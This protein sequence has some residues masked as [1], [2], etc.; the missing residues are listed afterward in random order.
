M[1][2]SNDVKFKRPIFIVFLTIT[3]VLAIITAIGS[4]HI[5]YY[6]HISE[7]KKQLYNADKNDVDML[8]SISENTD[9]LFD[10]EIYMKFENNCIGNTNNN[11]LSFGNYAR[12]KNIV[13]KSSD[14]TYLI[15]N[16][17][18]K[19]ILE[20]SS[21][22]INIMENEIFFRNDSDRK[23]Y[24]YSLKD[25]ITK[26]E[27]DA[28]CGEMVVTKRGIYYIDYS[29]ELLNYY[30][31]Q[32]NGTKYVIDSKVL[33]FAVAGESLFVLT[34]DKKLELITSNNFIKHI[35]EGVDKFFYNGNI[36][37]QKNS[38][39]YRIDS[40]TSAEQVFDKINKGRL[41]YASENFVFL[42]DNNK[43]KRFNI[44]DMNNE[45]QI[46]TLKNTDVFKC[47]YE[48][49]KGYEVVF[50]SKNNSQYLIKYNNISK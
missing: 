1:E 19:I 9:F 14:K 23:I 36:Y 22:Y 16:D 40:L 43:I 28:N 45:E 38:S 5:Y 18:E 8:F 34:N 10:K 48:T 20:N 41:I 32:T 21:S 47:M 29:T 2:N 11:L 26:C 7:I 33:S 46:Y 3:C 42:L 37:I 39:I 13:C 27:I 25:N 49:E 31:F 12:K 24:K 44:F 4:Y 15:T 30:S 50:Y 35:T 17:N 6:T